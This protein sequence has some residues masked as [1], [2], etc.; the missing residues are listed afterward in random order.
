VCGSLGLSVFVSLT[1]GRS[2]Q[3]AR[4]TARPLPIV[5]QILSRDSAEQ[6]VVEY[7][8]QPGAFT[9]SSHGAMLCAC[10]STGPA[11][12]YTRPAGRF[13][14]CDDGRDPGQRVN[15]N[16]SSHFDARCCTR[17]GLPRLSESCSFIIT[18]YLATPMTVLHRRARTRPSGPFRSRGAPH[19]RPRLAASGLDERPNDQGRFLHGF[20][21]NAAKPTPPPLARAAGRSSARTPP[22]PAP[23][24]AK[25]GVTPAR[26]RRLSHRCVVGKKKLWFAN[27]PRTGALA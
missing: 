10:S 23:T 12:T 6:F 8:A 24:P 18:S 5:T 9:Y 13:L 27:A 17:S 3:Q 15:L 19:N 7:P 14:V 22:D 11:A 20:R 2:S 21:T 26:T 4:R 1:C 16:K 25:A